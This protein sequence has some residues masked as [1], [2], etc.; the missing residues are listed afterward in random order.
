MRTLSRRGFVAGAAALPLIGLMP[1]AASTEAQPYTP[2][3]GM[4]GPAKSGKT[5]WLR[6]QFDKLLFENINQIFYTVKNNDE[7]GI[8]VG[9]NTYYYGPGKD[10]DLDHVDY[11]IWDDYQSSQIYGEN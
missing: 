4:F 6:T 1:F 10:V 3:I 2:Q 5:E 11:V 9:G 8:I 7:R